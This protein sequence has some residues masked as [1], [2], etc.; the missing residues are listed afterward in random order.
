MWAKE[1]GIL[2]GS[3]MTPETNKNATKG[4][5]GVAA[6]QL[7]GSLCCVLLFSVLSISWFYF[8]EVGQTHVLLAFGKYHIDTLFAPTQKYNTTKVPF[9]VHNFRRVVPHVV[10]ESEDDWLHPKD[11]F[12]KH[13]ESVYTPGSSEGGAV[14]FKGMA[15]AH[16]AYK[17]WSIDYLAKTIGNA[18]VRVERLLEDRCENGLPATSWLANVGVDDPPERKPKPKKP[19]HIIG[20]ANTKGIQETT[21]WDHRYHRNCIVSSDNL[22]T[23]ALEG[24]SNYMASTFTNYLKDA[25]H[26]A[27]YAI[28]EVP[29]ALHEDILVPSSILCNFNTRHL[30]GG[31]TEE[32]KNVGRIY[33]VDFWLSVPPKGK[34]GTSVFHYDMNHAVMCLYEGRKDWLMV[35]P[36]KQMQYMDFLKKNYFMVSPW[37]TSG[38]DYADFNQEYISEEDLKMYK[39]VD[40]QFIRQE[41]GDCLY[42]PPTFPHQTRTYGTSIAISMLWHKY[43]G[44]YEPKNCEGV[45]H[46][47]QKHRLKDMDL[48]WTHPGKYGIDGKA[49][50]GYGKIHLGF[51]PWV[52]TR[53]TLTSTLSYSMKDVKNNNINVGHFM[54]AHGSNPLKNKYKTYI[55]NILNLK[56]DTFAPNSDY[57]SMLERCPYFAVNENF[58]F[59]Y[60]FEESVVDKTCEESLDNLWSLLGKSISEKDNDDSRL[61]GNGQLRRDVP[62]TYSEI[63]GPEFEI[64]FRNMSSAYDMVYDDRWLETKIL[65]PRKRKR[66][67]K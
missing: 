5:G 44:L 7:V 39:K 11:F 60:E 32:K 64:Y 57:K 16:P 67:S 2:A 20:D 52:V 33:E 42:V 36:R 23:L 6:A 30:A 12:K 24:K 21:Q 10:W 19:Y 17:K 51:A 4:K 59:S 56:P 40:V 61:D 13:I 41:A 58:M 63:Y 18:T 37:D 66:T 8:I 9:G 29:E 62:V 53:D 14:L 35:D 22:T 45:E 50:P 25:E 49:M 47:A 15:K 1:T 31:Y 46:P 38:S 54:L 43:D 34:H 26:D 3:T 48:T 27:L 28:S 55:E 65:Y